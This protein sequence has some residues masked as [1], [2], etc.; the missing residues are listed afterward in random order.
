MLACWDSPDYAC[1]LLLYFVMLP[2][3]IMYPGLEGRL[4]GHLAKKGIWWHSVSLKKT[5]VASRL[6][7]RN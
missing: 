4:N 6:T 3:N 2:L 7:L 1:F 5:F